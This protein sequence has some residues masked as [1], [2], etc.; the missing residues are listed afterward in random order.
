MR[1]LRPEEMISLSIFIPDLMK[2]GKSWKAVIGQKVGAKGNSLGFETAGLVHSDSS[3][4]LPT[5]EIAFSFP[6]GL[7]RAPLGGTP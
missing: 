2:S 5:L 3:G 1:K 4:F 7:G 6:M